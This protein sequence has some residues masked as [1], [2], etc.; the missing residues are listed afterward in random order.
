[1]KILSI[2]Q[3]WAWAI[4]HAG[5]DIENRTWAT[6]F[7]GRFLVHA[8]KSFDMEGWRWLAINV[9]RFPF[10]LPPSSAFLVGE[11]EGCQRGGIIGSVELID[12]VE[13]HGSQWFSGPY[14]L[15][16]QNPKPAA[17]QA[18]KGKLGFFTL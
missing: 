4:I 11:M 14:G 10:T 2:K 18:S 8:S 15:V 16:L 5:K 3:P 1:M 13:S 12:C 7:R 9:S 17:F 6:K